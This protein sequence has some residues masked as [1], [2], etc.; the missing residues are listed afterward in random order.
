MG[1]LLAFLKDHR[2]RI[3]RVVAVV[4]V[5][6]VGLTL[7]DAAPREV[8]VRYR[9]GPDHRDVAE[10]RIA[11][12]QDGDEL[13]VVSFRY[14]RGGPETIFHTVELSPGRYDVVARLRRPDE[15]QT[16]TRHLEVPSDGVVRIDLFE[17]SPSLA[18]GPR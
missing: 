7:F 13:K 5:L 6:L 17:T 12:V 10:A 16:V 15:V 18:G 14:E 4:G 2:R 11:Y 8:A 3:A 1:T 9:L